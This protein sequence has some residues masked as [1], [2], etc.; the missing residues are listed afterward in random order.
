MSL[1]TDI[2]KAVVTHLNAA[3]FETNFQAVFAVRPEYKLAGLDE[4]K[5]VVVPK[6]LQVERASRAVTQYT[7]SVD[8]GVLQR[9]GN[10]SPEQAVTDCGMLVDEIIDFLASGELSAVPEATFRDIIN[11][12]IYSPEHLGSDRTFCSVLTVR[13]TLLG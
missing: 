8:I 3:D 10:V 5:V 11:E 7:V 1:V 2:A 12:P 4:L 6:S 13:Y 9:I